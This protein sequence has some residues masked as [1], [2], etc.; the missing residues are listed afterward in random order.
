MWYV[1]KRTSCM[2]SHNTFDTFP[3]ES[4]K[5]QISTHNYIYNVLM[6]PEHMYE[7]SMSLEVQLICLKRYKST[8]HD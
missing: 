8:L 4:C 6:L 5:T 3:E 2:W 7:L 1:G